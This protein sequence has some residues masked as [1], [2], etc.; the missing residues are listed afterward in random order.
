MHSQVKKLSKHLKQAN[1]LPTSLPVWFEDSKSVANLN[2]GELMEK[3]DRERIYKRRPGTYG[4]QGRNIDIFPGFLVGMNNWQNS[5]KP[6]EKF[7][8]R[9]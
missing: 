1:Q 4:V 8:I 7:V 6:T 5:V 9:I 3:E 2:A